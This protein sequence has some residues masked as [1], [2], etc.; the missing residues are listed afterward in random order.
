MKKT[1]VTIDELLEM[2]HEHYQPYQGLFQTTSS[3]YMPWLVTYYNNALDIDTHIVAN[4][5]GSRTYIATTFSDIETPLSV[6]KKH[7]GAWVSA[8]SENLAQLYYASIKQYEPLDNYD[9]TSTITVEKLGQEQHT[10]LAQTTNTTVG[11]MESTNNVESDNNSETINARKPFNSSTSIE[12]GKVTVPTNH[13]ESADTINTD[14]TTTNTGSNNGTD[15]L[16]F[17]DRKDI[18]TEHTSGNIGVTTSSA[19]LKEF[20]EVKWEINF[21]ETMFRKFLF[22]YTF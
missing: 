22:E 15:T 19:L 5:Y 8:N 3:G 20:W 1:E 11:T 16:T 12:N 14:S 13:T 10:N 21:Y 18:T 2:N 6:F 17:S 4:K 9:K 7:F